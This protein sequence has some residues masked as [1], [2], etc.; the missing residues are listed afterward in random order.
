[1]CEHSDGRTA[2]VYVYL[3][4]IA[5]PSFVQQFNRESS[6]VVRSSQ[7]SERRA[8]S[9]AYSRSVTKIQTLRS[10]CSRQDQH[11]EGRLF[12]AHSL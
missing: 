10:S 7:L 4:L 5:M 1:M 8:I 2:K 6:I 12:D 11:H 3:Q 9:S